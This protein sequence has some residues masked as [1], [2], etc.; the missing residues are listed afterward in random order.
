MKHK[1]VPGSCECVTIDALLYKT[2]ALLL[3]ILLLGCFRE[4][5]T[6][7]SLCPLCCSWSLRTVFIIFLAT[8]RW[9]L[10]PLNKSH[11]KYSWILSSQVDLSCP[12]KRQHSGQLF[13]YQYLWKLWATEN[14]INFF[15]QQ[16]QEHQIASIFQTWTECDFYVHKS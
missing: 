11:V 14:A 10:F 9:V 7:H 2:T 5:E 1:F 12:L 13:F 16:T 3:I 8:E 15:N 6:Q 4:Q